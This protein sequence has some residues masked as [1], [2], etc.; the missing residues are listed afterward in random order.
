M[1]PQLQALGFWG[2]S[3]SS[4][5]RVDPGDLRGIMLEISLGALR[6][7]AFHQTH[8][9]TSLTSGWQRTYGTMRDNISLRFGDIGFMGI[10]WFSQDPARTNLTREA[11]WVASAQDECNAVGCSKP[12]CV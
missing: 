4:G 10:A 3:Q 11:R 1:L 6:H 12:F 9:F 2:V 7:L 5:D 8:I